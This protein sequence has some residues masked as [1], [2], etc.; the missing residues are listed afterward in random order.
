VSSASAVC[1][2]GG[3]SAENVIDESLASDDES[4]GQIPQTP[5]EFGVGYIFPRRNMEQNMPVR[6]KNRIGQ[7]LGPAEPFHGSH[8]LA[9]SMLLIW[10]E[11]P[12]P[13]DRP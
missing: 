10:T 3:V 9:K 5:D 6:A 11:D 13:V 7:N 4:I 12:A 8:E 1:G 2:S